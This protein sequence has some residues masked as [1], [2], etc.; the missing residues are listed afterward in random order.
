MFLD[1]LISIRYLRQKKLVQ[2]LLD[3][4]CLLNPLGGG[5]HPKGG[6]AFSEPGRGQLH[7]EPHIRP[8]SCHVTS[9]P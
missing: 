1:V 9:L 8:I 6:T 3:V 2:F 7:I 5:T 4:Y